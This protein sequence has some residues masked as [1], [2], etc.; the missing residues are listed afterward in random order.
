MMTRAKGHRDA[1]RRRRVW[2]PF[3]GLALLSLVF[4]GNPGCGCGDDL[5]PGLLSTPCCCTFVWYPQPDLANASVEIVVVNGGATLSPVITP[6]AL[7]GVNTDQPQT[8]TV[9]VA[10]DH[11]LGAQVG[12]EFRDS[13][14]ATV[15]GSAQI[16]YNVQCVPT[17]I[18]GARTPLFSP[19]CGG[20]GTCCC[21]LEWTNTSPVGATF[22]VRVELQNADASLGATVTPSVVTSVGPMGTALFQICVN[23]DHD[24]GATMTVN[25]VDDDTDQVLESAFLSYD[26]RCTITQVPPPLGL[27]ASFNFICP[28]E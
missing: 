17:V 8:F 26:Q 18:E 24:L 19:N 16:V 21:D 6:S 1:R 7:V 22:N 4:I 27:V 13:G 9:C 12:I 5:T 14:T 28:S 3:L 2:G 25:I 11:A 20:V 15:Y 10:P 23:E